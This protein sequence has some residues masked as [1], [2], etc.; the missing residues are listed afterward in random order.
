[1]REFDLQDL[2]V[3]R[4]SVHVFDRFTDRMRMGVFERRFALVVP[5]YVKGVEDHR[6]G[7]SR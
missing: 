7:K 1:M 5:S 4:S 6:T 2:A 3:E